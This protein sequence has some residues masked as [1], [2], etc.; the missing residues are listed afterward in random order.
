M[1]NLNLLIKIYNEIKLTLILFGINIKITF[2]NLKNIL[3]NPD[4]YCQFET[5]KLTVKGV[6]SIYLAND[7]PNESKY[8]ITFENVYRMDLDGTEIEPTNLIETNTGIHEIIIKSKEI[9]IYPSQFEDQNQIQEIDLSEC[10]ITD[11][12][13]KF[14][15]SN[16]GI[17]KVVLPNSVKKINN[18][19]FSGGKVYS[20]TILDINL[21]NIE[22]VG[23]SGFVWRNFNKDIVMNNVTL[24]PGAFAYCSMPSIT[25][26]NVKS[27]G[28]LATEIS[29]QNT[30][31]LSPI[32]II[33]STNNVI[34]GSACF[35]NGVFSSTLEKLV[36]NCNCIMYT[37]IVDHCKY[38]HEIYYYGD[39]KPIFLQ[40]T[41]NKQPYWTS[42]S[43]KAW[44]ELY[45]AAG[46][47]TKPNYFHIR[48]DSTWTEKDLDPNYGT[49]TGYLFNPD[50]CG[51][52]LVKDL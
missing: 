35:S 32:V 26:N 45:P 48:K 17:K 14:C 3:E 18:D 11:I 50:V 46:E 25:L 22:Y 6:K 21:D 38:L 42:I 51:F 8:Q 19:A 34:I 49:D 15:Y 16:T 23:K 31:S 43:P 40:K 37:E 1:G 44:Q 24:E 27:I 36:L 9:P 7:P 2:S 10:N 52:I 41:S 28:Y 12:P 5:L 30:I 39:K 13:Q 29:G 47:L 20:K 33:N 4:D